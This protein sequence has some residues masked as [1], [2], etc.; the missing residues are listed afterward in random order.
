MVFMKPIHSRIKLEQ[1][2]G[3][4][5][6]SHETCKYPERL[7]DGHKT[8]FLI[9]DFWQNEFAKPAEEVQAQSLPVMVSLFNTRLKLLAHYLDDQDSPEAQQV[10][11]LDEDVGAVHE[12]SKVGEVFKRGPSLGVSASGKA[13]QI[14]DL[15]LRFGRLVEIRRENGEESP[16]WPGREG[17]VFGGM[18]ARPP[19]RGG[20]GWRSAGLGTLFPA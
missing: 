1:M 2:I 6:R 19:H 9:I 3:R 13:S 5:T 4:G 20:A 17:R 14:H 16:A 11:A 12:T 8:D 15:P 10:I 18:A 7:P